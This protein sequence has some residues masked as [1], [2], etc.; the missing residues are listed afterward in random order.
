MKEKHTARPCL[1]FVIMGARQRRTKDT[2]NMPIPSSTAVAKTPT[3]KDGQQPE[4]NSGDIGNLEVHLTLDR[5]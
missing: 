1:V 2:I 4:R 5:R 3:L